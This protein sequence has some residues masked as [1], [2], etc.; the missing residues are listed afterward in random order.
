ML[1]D[2][3]ILDGA[4]LERPLLL[5]LRS[6]HALSE[7]TLHDLATGELVASV[8]VPGL[9]TI[10]G[11]LEHPDGGPF[12]WFSYT[13]FRTAAERLPVRRPH[14]RGDGVGAVAR[15]CRGRRGRGQAGHLCLARRDGSSG[16]SFC[17][18]PVSRTGRVR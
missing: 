13:D 9:G 11:L 6:R 1:N 5:A 15:R 14:R 16:C 12:A 7:L 2:F 10:Q 17:R 8:P 18:R 4:Q 3:V